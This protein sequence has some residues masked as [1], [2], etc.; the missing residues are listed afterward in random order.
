MS[1]KI[2]KKK[3]QRQGP[4]GLDLLQQVLPIVANSGLCP[5][6]SLGRLEQTCKTFQSVLVH[7]EE[8]WV[9]AY[10]SNYHAYN[11][12]ATAIPT[13]GGYRRLVQMLSS[14][15]GNTIPIQPGPMPRQEFPPIAPPSLTECDVMILWEIHYNKRVVERGSLTAKE[16]REVLRE[17]QVKV[18]FAN[19]IVISKAV[20]HDHLWFNIVQVVYTNSLSLQF[21][22]KILRLSDM[23]VFCIHDTQRERQYE[24]F[25]RVE[26]K[27]QRLQR[28][29]RPRYQLDDLDFD[30]DKTQGEIYFGNPKALPLDLSMPKDLWARFP[31]CIS[32]IGTIRLEATQRR[33]I[34]VSGFDL[35]FFKYR[36]NMDD[37]S[38]RFYH[39]GELPNNGVTLLHLLSYLHS[40]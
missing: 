4:S 24:R 35:S 6:L 30:N 26:V 28:G 23:K 18:T 40:E 16:I 15:A 25:P 39:D 1:A 13:N 29:D 22:V 38:E 14:L 36:Q 8:I 3:K 27:R 19:K 31:Y 33:E 7:D 5:V 17:G 20:V 9:S 21:A 10:K 37:D 12:P 2:P 11:I 32:T 34:A